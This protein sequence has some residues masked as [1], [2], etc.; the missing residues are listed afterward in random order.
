MRSTASTSLWANAAGSLTDKFTRYRPIIRIL[1]AAVFLTTVLISSRQSITQAGAQAPTEGAALALPA[2][3]G[4]GIP[5]NQAITVEFSRAMD[6]A[7]VADALV[8]EPETDVYLTW[9]ADG[10]RLEIAPSDRWETDRRYLVTVGPQALAATGDRIGTA[11][12]LTFTTQTAP[13]VRRFEVLTPGGAEGTAQPLSGHLTPL[14]GYESSEI[15]GASTRTTISVEFTTA[16]SESNVEDRFVIQPYVPG[17]FSWEGNVLSFTPDERLD[18]DAEYTVT[19]AGA[20][21][22]RGNPVGREA[23]FTFTTQPMAEVVT[24]EPAN[25]AEDVTGDTVTIE[26]SQPMDVEATNEAFGLWDIM[27]AATKLPGEISWN[28]DHTQL[29]FVADAALGGLRFHAIRLGEGATDVDG[30][31]VKGEWRFWTG[32]MTPQAVPQA[33]VAAAPAPEPTPAPAYSLPAY[34]PGSPLEAYALEQ[35]N[36]ARAAYGFPPLAMDP[37]VA[38]AA[39]AHAWDQ[40][41]NGYYGHTSLDGSTQEMRLRAAG[42]S[43]GLAGENLCHH[44]AMSALGTLNWCHTSFMAEPYPGHWNHIGNILGRDYTRVGIGIAEG[45]GRVVIVWDFV[46]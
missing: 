19:L 24:V 14:P 3:V 38:E 2:S 32:T 8:V 39:R 28:D 1:V 27:G 21:D 35:I 17:T 42:A 12:E 25:G 33:A 23:V 43:F 11:T 34:A 20:T 6:A 9:S 45:N 26:F 30:N 29:T 44:Y 16:M 15:E 13:A 40:V 46:Q 36:S 18:P 41:R 22:R 31:P 4:V 5:T 7:S 37:A 10:T